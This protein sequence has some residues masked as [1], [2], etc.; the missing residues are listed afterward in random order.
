MTDS[1]RSEML[2]A[3]TGELSASE[4]EGFERALATDDALRAEWER[5]QKVSGLL[6]ESR[7]DSFRPFF[8]ARVAQRIKSEREASTLSD[9]TE[10]AEVSAETESLTD[11]LVWLFRPL[12]PVAIAVVAFLALSNWNERELIG[13]DASFLAAI[14][15]AV[16]ATP[17][18]AYV[19]DM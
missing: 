1:Y 8:A 13:D 15:A 12:A 16:P 6:Q 17:E 19:L 7:A 2:K 5:L 9:S 18:A 10:L 4:R 11:A 3:L 14:F